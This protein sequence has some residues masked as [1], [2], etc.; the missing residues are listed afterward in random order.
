L[1]LVSHGAIIFVLYEA[2]KSWA[3][4]T[5]GQDL[6]SMHFF[7]MG[8]FTKVVSSVL[9]YPIQVIKTRVQQRDLVKNTRARPLVCR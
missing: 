7:V 1:L 6:N 3:P 4:R 8:A 9:T 2:I 5:L